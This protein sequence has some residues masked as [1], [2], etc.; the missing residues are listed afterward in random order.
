[1]KRQVGYKYF[2]HLVTE[3]TEKTKVIFSFSPNP[4]VP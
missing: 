2:N 3:L 4:S 1:M